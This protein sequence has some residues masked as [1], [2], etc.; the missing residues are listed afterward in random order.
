MKVVVALSSLAIIGLICMACTTPIVSKAPPSPQAKI[1]VLGVHP[2]PK[3]ADQSTDEL[4]VYASYYVSHF[5]ENLAPYTMHAQFD[6]NKGVTIGLGYGTSNVVLKVPSGQAQLT[7]SLKDLHGIARSWR[8]KLPLTMYI[9]I[10]HAT[11]TG[12]QI[13]GKSK[14]ITFPLIKGNS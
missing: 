6:T 11:D 1:S 8:L 5:D 14:P 12:T 4:L 13:I 3:S 9:V 2:D 7:I 10:D